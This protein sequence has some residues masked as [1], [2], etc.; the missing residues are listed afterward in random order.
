MHNL[1]SAESLGSW[2]L[3]EDDSKK[4]LLLPMSRW[5]LGKD[6]QH[7]VYCGGKFNLWWVVLKRDSG[8]RIKQ[9]GA[10]PDVK[11]N[12]CRS[13]GGKFNNFQSSHSHQLMSI[14]PPLCR[15]IYIRLWRGAQRAV[16]FPFW[17]QP[18]PRYTQACFQH[19]QELC[20]WQAAKKKKGA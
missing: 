10:V 9:G 18:F 11:A 6:E 3:R 2:W 16:C 19:L 12:I 14:K 5:C 15:D 8:A 13:Q 4:D 20:V 1:S 17:Q 7:S